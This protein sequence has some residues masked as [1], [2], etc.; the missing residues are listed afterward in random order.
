MANRAVTRARHDRQGDIIALGNP[1]PGGAGW[2]VR[3][4]DD[5]IS[6][7]NLGLHT[8]YVPWTSGSTPIRVVDGPTRPYLRTDR[9][10][11]TRNNLDDLDEI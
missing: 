1:G 2:S 3:A 11:T 6:D 5:I 10:A 4:S 8:Y 7:I 9:D